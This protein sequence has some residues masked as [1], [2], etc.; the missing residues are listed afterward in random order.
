M[1]LD[2]IENA[3]LYVGLNAGFAKAFE[4]LKDKTL[5]HKKD[6]KCSVEGDNLFYTVQRYTT[7]P[8]SEGKL[9]VHR[10]Y[11]DIQ[12]LLS[13]VEILGYAPLKG[14]TVAEEYN[15]EKDIAFFETPKELTKVKLEPGLFCILFS[16]DAHL[17]ALAAGL[18]AFKPRGEVSPL[19]GPC[20]KVD[21][22]AE[23]RKVVIKVR[24]GQED[25]NG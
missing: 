22:P 9:E 23:V 14:L 13:G 1:I 5:S 3:R 24:L 7:K 12:F 18:A 11:I 25:K 8:I 16:D 4:L 20:R 6:G 19:G 21:K 10:K 17:P 15:P 2:R